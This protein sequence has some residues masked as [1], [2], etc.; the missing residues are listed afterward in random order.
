[1]SKTQLITGVSGG[2]GYEMI[3]LAASTDIHE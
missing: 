1:M 3:E 2:F